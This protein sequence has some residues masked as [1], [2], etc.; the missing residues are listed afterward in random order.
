MMMMKSRAWILRYWLSPEHRCTSRTSLSHSHKNLYY[1]YCLWQFQFRFRFSGHTA[2]DRVM[3]K[4][5][6]FLML[7][8]MSTSTPSFQQL[9]ARGILYLQLWS[10]LTHFSPS[11][12]ASVFISDIDSRDHRPLCVYS[13]HRRW[14]WSWNK[15]TYKFSW[16][17]R[18]KKQKKSS[19]VSINNSSLDSKSLQFPL[20][21]L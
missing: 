3:M 2:E 4:C 18:N 16:K 14:R 21:T 12:Q 5:T 1:S 9:Y 11:K 7:G 20:D 8:P 15:K 13:V 17:T 10:I 6:K 19:R